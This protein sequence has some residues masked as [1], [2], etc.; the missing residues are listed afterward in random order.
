MK[1]R[2]T[3]QICADLRKERG[4]LYS[5]RNSSLKK[6]QSSKISSKNKSKYQKQYDRASKR[7][8]YIKEYLFKC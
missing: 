4:G 1:R 3:E 6:L 5:K 2:T 8:D 7:L